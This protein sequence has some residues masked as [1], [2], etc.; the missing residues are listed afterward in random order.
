MITV[1]VRLFATLRRQFPELGI[2]EALRVDL[3]E[4]A[5]VDQLVR[6]MK[7]PR[8]HV[9]VVFVNGTIQEGDYRLA[10]GDEVGIF[11]PVG[12]G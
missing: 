2:G 7:L 11:P 12:G 5:T 3:A 4:G 6:N 10:D 9:K 8:E 1:G